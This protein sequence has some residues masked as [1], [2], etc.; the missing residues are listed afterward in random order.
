VLLLTFQVGQS[1]NTVVDK[2]TIDSLEQLK[3]GDSILNKHVL[4]L[5]AV[6]EEDKVNRKINE[7]KDA[8]KVIGKK[9]K[10]FNQLTTIL[11]IALITIL[12]LLTLSLFKQQRDKLKMTN[13]LM[14]YKQK[15]LHLQMNPHLIFNCLG[16]LSGFMINKETD[17]GV[18]Y[19]AKFSKLMRLTL[20]YSQESLISLEKEIES[21]EN[22]LELE[23]LRFDN[24]FD[25]TITKS[26]NIEDDM[27][28]PP[29]LIQPLI[30][31]AIN[32][33][34]IPQNKKG[35]IEICFAVDEENKIVCEIIDNG[36][37]INASI[38]NKK[39]SVTIHKSMALNII[40][41]RLSIIARETKKIARLE[42]YQINDE[43]KQSKGTKVIVILP[44]LYKC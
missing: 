37:G 29:L 11:S 4:E 20:E 25:F 41:Q 12:S 9:N 30:E 22:Y 1:Q 3:E 10:T 34:V 8:A 15:A 42:A 32:H 31:N 28:I 27:A 21:L 44:I 13:E 2:E 17:R 14:V 23:K 7:I 26:Q 6:T 18:K 39:A 35:K 33:G 36:V 16:A 43:A 38:E 19:L 5:L 40:K 24:K